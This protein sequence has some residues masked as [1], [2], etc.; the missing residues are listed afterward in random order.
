MKALSSKL[1]EK[2]GGSRPG[3]FGNLNL[4][5]GELVILVNGRNIDTLDGLDTQLKDGD[6]VTLLPPFAGG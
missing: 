4:D 3:Y 5:K 2:V 6:S 1:S